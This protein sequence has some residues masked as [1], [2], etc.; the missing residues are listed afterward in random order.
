MFFNF[1]DFNHILSSVTIKVYYCL[2]FILMMNNKKN[3]A[4][5]KT[6]VKISS[7]PELQLKTAATVSNISHNTENTTNNLGLKGRL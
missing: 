5:P 7:T 3:L 1:K 2:L 6:N 4:K